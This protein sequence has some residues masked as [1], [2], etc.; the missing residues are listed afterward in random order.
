MYRSDG[1]IVKAPSRPAIAQLD[2]LES[3]H[4]HYTTHLMMTSRGC[5]WRCSFCGADTT[6]G[7]GYRGQSTAY[8]LDSLEKQLERLPVRMVQVKDDTFTTNKKRVIELCRGIRDRGLQFLWSCDTRVDVISEELLREMRLAGCERLSLG[9]E[10]GSQRI[11]DAIDKKITPEEIVT[12]TAMAKKYGIKVRFFMMLGNRGETRET[13]EE[14]LRFLERAQPHSY[15]FSCLSIYPGTQDFTDAEAA[16]WFDRGVYFDGDFQEYKVPYDSTEEDTQLFSEW[17]QSNKGVRTMYR[18]SVADCESVCRE[19]G[20]HHAAVMD[21]GGAHFRAGDLAAAEAHVHRALELGYPLPGL[22]Y[23]YLACIAAARRDL[24]GVQAHF[25]AALAD[26]QHHVLKQNLQT[27]RAWLAEGGPTRGLPLQLAA[28]HD[29]QLFERTQQP[30]LP[31]PLPDDFATWAP[32]L[33]PRP[34]P[35]SRGKLPVLRT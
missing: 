4:E 17:F 18:P 2:A 24:A 22:A 9:V 35:A 23:N 28:H 27:F 7:R 13:F 30:A 25:K 26:P 11:L 31:G 33:H 12:A 8:V 16:G 21:L 3:P 14:T 15:I 1:E 10:S 5:P 32:A 6:W 29:F 20:D 19:L 34:A